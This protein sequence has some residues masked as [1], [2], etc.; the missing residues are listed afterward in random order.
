M[1]FKNLIKHSTR[2]P[3]AGLASATRQVT[4]GI[5]LLL[6]AQTGL[7]HAQPQ[8]TQ[9]QHAQPN[10]LWITVE[11]IT[12]FIGAYGNH[13]V[14]TPNID[15]LAR[16]GVLYTHA[17]QTA[18]VCAPARAAL[19]TGMYPTSVGAHH[20]RTGGGELQIPGRSAPQKPEGIPA[21]YSV[22]LPEQVRAF[23]EYLRRAGY[24]TTNNQKQDYQFEAP[25]TVWDENGPA[26]SFRNR[27]KG[28]PFFSVFNFFLTHES[29]VALRKD[30]LRVDPASV[31]VPP[32]FPNTTAVRGD[33]ARMYT[34]IELLDQQVGELIRMLK[35]DGLY[36][37]TTIF[38][39]AD[40]GGNLPWMKRELLERG[41]RVPFIVRYPGGRHAGTRSDEL[42]SGVDLA[43]TMLSL[44]GVRIPAYMQGQA[45]LGDQRATV[46]RRYVFAARDRMD[47]E[48]DR[49]RMVRDARYRY[50]YNYMPEKPYYQNL[51]FRM[52][53]PM[54][55]DILQRKADGTLPATTATWFQTKPVEELYDAEQDPWELHNLASDPRY[56][57]KL[58]ELRL[59]FHA[60][61]AQYGDMGGIPERDMLKQ[62]WLGG[63]APPATAMPEVHRAGNGVRIACATPGA[64]IGYWIE[65]P[66]SMS[67]DTP[68]IVQSW[69]YERLAGE[70]LGKG[71]ARVGDQRAAPPRWTV[72]DGE[73]IPLRQGEILHINAMRIG[74]TRALADYVDGKAEAPR[75]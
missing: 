59:A 2:K 39:F 16:E 28:K 65:R 3:L 33:I 70:M 58:E 75:N 34:N 72:Y 7:L 32:I 30:P 8:H 67:A 11:D 71:F 22:V 66:D 17:Y 40:N 18:G 64:S 62:M 1:H 27:P 29:M 63:N 47:T 41:T 57:R 4:G 46:P 21:V 68:H 42:V 14:K 5:L 26:A 20:M 49:V 15:Q 13:E 25:V 24:Y 10:I 53:L 69:D 35:D 45:F 31:S 51:T 56:K 36:D 9:P 6:V 55:R 23:P 50:L 38:L 19:I 44:A 48:Y 52:M 60:W 61:T 12:T 74:Y 73:I 37:Q 54:M 43:P